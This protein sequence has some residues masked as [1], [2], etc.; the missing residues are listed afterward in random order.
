[1]V[2]PRRPCG[3]LRACGLGAPENNA[4]EVQTNQK[5][6]SLGSFGK[7]AKER[8]PWMPKEEGRPSESCASGPGSVMLTSKEVGEKMAPASCFLRWKARLAAATAL[9]RS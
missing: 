9:G 4:K 7:A 2:H 1:M 3:T 8:W 6:G 5:I